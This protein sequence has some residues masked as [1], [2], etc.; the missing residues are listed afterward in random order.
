ME[1]AEHARMTG[2][3]RQ[4]V[5]QYESVLANRAARGELWP[6]AVYGVA[7]SYQAL[8]EYGTAIPYYQRLYVMYGAYT[9]LVAR[10]Y[11]NSGVCFE[12][13]QDYAAAAKTYTEL[14]E[15][16]RLTHYHETGEARM[17]LRAL[18]EEGNYVQ[19]VTQ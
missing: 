10:A 9:T 5:T 15:D 12:H 3:F 13:L 8:G 19:P 7:S 11:F 16:R 18:Q 14:L 1:Q 17:R 4:A 2:L 6:K